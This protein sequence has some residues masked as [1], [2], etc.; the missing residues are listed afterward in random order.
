MYIKDDLYLPS[1]IGDDQKSVGIGDEE[2][3]GSLLNNTK[4]TSQLNFL[5]IWPSYL[6]QFIKKASP[7]FYCRSAIT[8]SWFL[9]ITLINFQLLGTITY[10]IYEALMTIYDYTITLSDRTMNFIIRRRE[11]ITWHKKYQSGLW[12]LLPDT[13]LPN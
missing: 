10:L 2:R 12:R 6:I 3:A 4:A 5:N 9:Q 7:E 8:F 11:T 1:L 13:K